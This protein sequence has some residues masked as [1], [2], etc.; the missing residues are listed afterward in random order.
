MASSVRGSLIGRSIPRLS[1]CD[2]VSAV[3][4]DRHDDGRQRVDLRRDAEADHRV[5]L[6][7]QRGRGAAGAG[8][9]EGDD[10]FVDRQREGEQRAGDHRRQDDRQGH[11]PEGGERGGAEIGGGLDDRPV[12]TLQPGAHHRADEGEVEDDMGEDDG[13]QAHG[14]IEH[15]K[16]RQQRDRQHDVGNDHRREDQRFEPLAVLPAHLDADRQQRA[17]QRGDGRRRPAPRSAC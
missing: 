12:E 8:G 17:E 3:M 11:A 2:R 7:R 16:E 5:D 13:V 1:R 10:E 15:G 9:E 6:H 14:Q 4:R